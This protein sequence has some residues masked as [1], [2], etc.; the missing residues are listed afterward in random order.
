MY[1]KKKLVDAFRSH[2]FFIGNALGSFS[3]DL[4]SFLLVQG[5]YTCKI[6][7][8]ADKVSTTN[9]TTIKIYLVNGRRI[10]YQNEE[11]IL[12]IIGICMGE[13]CVFSLMGIGPSYM[14]L[15]TLL[16]IGVPTHDANVEVELLTLM[17]S[18]YY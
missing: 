14:T 11:Y 18:L 16:S 10:I 3:S 5:I 13:R 1:L 12:V 2:H 6:Y 15:T 4:L 7:I 17:L 9:Y 8:K